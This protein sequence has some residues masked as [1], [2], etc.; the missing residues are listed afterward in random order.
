MLYITRF[1][2]HFDKGDKF[3]GQDVAKK[4]GATLKGINLFPMKRIFQVLIF[5]YIHVFRHLNS[6]PHIFLIFPYIFRHLNSLP[7]IFQNPNKSI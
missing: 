5:P 7:Y 6:L 2:H 4:M 3:C 1:C